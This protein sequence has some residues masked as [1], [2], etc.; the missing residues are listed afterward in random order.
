[1]R[2]VQLED[3]AGKDQVSPV[4]EQEVGVSYTESFGAGT[5]YTPHEVVTTP[6]RHHMRDPISSS[7]KGT[8]LHEIRS[9]PTW[10]NG[11]GFIKKPLDAEDDPFVVAT[12]PDQSSAAR[13][14][15]MVLNTE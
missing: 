13:K 7:P 12:A 15:C 6:A 1:M 5:S 2:A 9:S 14:L 10:R 3:G 8:R 4:M 11:S